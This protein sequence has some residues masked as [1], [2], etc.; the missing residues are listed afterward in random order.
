MVDGDEERL[1]DEGCVVTKELM[2]LRMY[3]TPKGK[4]R[5]EE[6]ATPN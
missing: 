4:H 6:T 2:V 5:E 3:P 1:I